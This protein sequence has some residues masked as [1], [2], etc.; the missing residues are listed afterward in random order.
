MKLSYPLIALS[1]VAMSAEASG[2]RGGSET[3][4]KRTQRHL[5]SSTRKCPVA[6]TATSA[7][8]VVA[9][10]EAKQ[11]PAMGVD[12]CLAVHLASLSAG[13]DIK[14]YEAANSLHAGPVDPITY[15]GDGS[16]LA[17]IKTSK[18]IEYYLE[19]GAN[20]SSTPKEFLDQAFLD[21]GYG[22]NVD[23]K[24]KTW[25]VYFVDTC[26]LREELGTKSI[27]VQIPTMSFW[28]SWLEALFPENKFSI[29]TIVGIA[30]SLATQTPFESFDELINCDAASFDKGHYADK[31]WCPNM[32]PEAKT[33]YQKCMPFGYHQTY[34]CFQTFFE[35][36]KSVWDTPSGLR[37]A[38]DAC[39]DVNQFNAANGFGWD[40]NSA[41]LN[42]SG[43]DYTSP[44]VV[45]PNAMSLKDLKQKLQADSY[46][47]ECD[48]N[49]VCSVR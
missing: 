45:V 48:N 37:A 1:Y 43:F 28:T 33:V 14:Q 13:T 46:T 24:D 17:W 49:S 19:L 31:D 35:Q 20:P 39:Q 16:A 9:C 7:E 32:P 30:E 23:V 11:Q 4:T 22:K 12:P 10:L 5:N 41:S 36:D 2:I 15:Q 44:E 29:K 27:G 3:D 21:I 25:I 8:E 34:K 26:K 42:P 40:P 6:G 38:L 18:S 47:I